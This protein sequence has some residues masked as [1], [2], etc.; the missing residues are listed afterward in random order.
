MVRSSTRTAPSTGRADLRPAA[1]R[2]STYYELKARQAMRIVGRPVRAAM[3][4]CA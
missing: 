4:N 1:D 2:P 3:S